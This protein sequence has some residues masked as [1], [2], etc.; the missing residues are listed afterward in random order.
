ML[1]MVRPSRF[2]Q[3]RENA[4]FGFPDSV[5]IDNTQNA[6]LSRC[7]MW[8]SQWSQGHLKDANRGKQIKY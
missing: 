5:R 1:L 8:K 2:L 7:M 4:S 3:E 6:R